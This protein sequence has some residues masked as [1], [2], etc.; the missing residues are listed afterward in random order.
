MN[1]GS[2]T[3]HLIPKNCSSYFAQNFYV[4]RATSTLVPNV[5][6]INEAGDILFETNSLGLRGAEP[7]AGQ[8]LAVVWGDSVVFS[9][10]RPGLAGWPEQIN[11]ESIDCLF[12]NGGVEGRFYPHTIL[13]ALEFNRKHTVALNLLTLGWMPADN[14]PV[15]DDL[16]DTL[17]ELP[18]PV[19]ITQPT[20]LNPKIAAKDLEAYINLAMGDAHFGFF[21]SEPYSVEHQVAFFQHISERN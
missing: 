1:S 4:D 12:L 5:V 18:N 20:S 8:N 21:G 15:H 13:R 16:L 11:D 10:F 2:K 19:L 6:C 9:L 17:A 7:K 3:V 14:R